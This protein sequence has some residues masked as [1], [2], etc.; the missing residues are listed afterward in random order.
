LMI[1][2]LTAVVTDAGE[3]AIINGNDNHQPTL[4]KGTSVGELPTAEPEN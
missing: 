3:T 2:V 4:M 1:V